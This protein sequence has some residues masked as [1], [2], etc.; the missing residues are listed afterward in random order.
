MKIKLLGVDDRFGIK[1]PSSE[2]I[3]VHKIYIITHTTI[4]N[5]L[6]RGVRGDVKKGKALKFQVT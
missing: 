2:L 5:F 1:M 3:L 4:T 6:Q